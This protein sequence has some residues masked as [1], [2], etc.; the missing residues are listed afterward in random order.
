MGMNPKRKKENEK[1]EYNMEVENGYNERTGFTQIQKLQMAE[2]LDI[3][4]R[5]VA[6][7]S[8]LDCYVS[9]DFRKGRLMGVV[10]AYS[11]LDLIDWDTFR[12]LNHAITHDLL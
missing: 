5:V 4:F 6:I 9:T 10:H 7:P 2:Q 11:T 8:L 12:N 3:L 1:M